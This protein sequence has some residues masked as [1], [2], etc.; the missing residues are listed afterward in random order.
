MD[1]GF[2]RLYFKERLHYHRSNITD[3]KLLTGFNELRVY[4]DGDISDAIP[5]HIYQLQFVEICITLRLR[6]CASQLSAISI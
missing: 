4:L 1:S 2:D 3:T 5:F 6:H